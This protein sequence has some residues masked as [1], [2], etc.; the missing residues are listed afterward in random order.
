MQ[1]TSSSDSSTEQSVD[2]ITSG[3]IRVYL[4][5]GFYILIGLVGVA[6]NT[7]S[8]HVMRSSRK[9]NQSKSYTLLMNQCL[10][11]C[12]LSVVV[13]LDFFLK[14]ALPSGEGGSLYCYVIYTKLIPTVVVMTSSYN[15]VALSLDR[16]V[17]VVWPIQHRVMVTKRRYTWI[18]AGIWCY[19]LFISLVLCLPVNGAQADGTCHF[20][21]KFPSLAVSRVFSVIFNTFYTFLPL[22]LM[23]FSYTVIYVT[24]ATTSTTDIPTHPDVGGKLKMNVIRMLATCVLLFFVCHI[25]RAYLSIQSRFTSINY[26]D[27]NVYHVSIILLE[28]N[29]VVNPFV[30]IIQYQDYKTELKR[31]WKML[32]RRRNKDDI[33]ISTINISTK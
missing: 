21:N 17:S 30:Y 18:C 10:I 8:M 19:G 14:Y 24:I 6:G 27:S 31:Q 28:C 12:T 22:S 5:T 29:T 25:L 23:L 13:T 7:T 9:I 2:D 16:M 4:M 15:L 3:S 26:V 11:D 33:S 32:T 20:W 1:S